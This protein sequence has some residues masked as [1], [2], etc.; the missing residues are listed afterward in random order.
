MHPTRTREVKAKG[1]GNGL[2][3]AGALAGML[4]LLLCSASPSLAG[5]AGEPAYDTARWVGRYC[6]TRACADAKASPLS[7]AA[8]FGFAVLGVLWLA[9]RSSAK[10]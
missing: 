3:R 7:H 2:A 6:T 5:G 9:G 8:G 4:V 10:N 1:G